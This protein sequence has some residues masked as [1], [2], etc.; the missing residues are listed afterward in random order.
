MYNMSA[1]PLDS[2]VL[3]DIGQNPRAIH[4]DVFG[5]NPTIGTTTEDVWWN[6]GTLVWPTTAAVISVTGGEDDDIGGTGIR[7]VDIHGLDEN[8][9]E[10]EENLIL[11]GTTPATTTLEFLRVNLC[12]AT[13]WGTGGQASADI[14]GSIGGDIQ[15][16]IAQGR[17]QTAKS[18][19]TIPAGKTANIRSYYAGSAGNKNVVCSF[20][21]R[22]VNEE[23]FF[24]IRELQLRDTYVDIPIKYGPFPEKTDI[25]ITG[26]A[27]SGTANL[28]AGCVFDIFYTTP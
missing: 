11:T 14:E 3:S 10:I 28:T 8:Y 24:L 18:Q 15:F 13:T 17:N 4:K 27:D 2:I 1:Q 22:L 23:G 5:R 9:N 7:S 21:Y 12:H 26:S 19:F 16:N 20:L 6:G 25:K